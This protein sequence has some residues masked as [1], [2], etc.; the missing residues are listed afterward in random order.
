[1][2]DSENVHYIAGGRRGKEVAD[3]AIT[4]AIAIFEDGNQEARYEV[5]TVL[6]TERDDWLRERNR[7][8]GDLGAADAAVKAYDAAIAKLSAE[9]E[10]ES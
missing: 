5:L 2:T 10:T 1:M 8:A 9:E 6:R 7:L 4:E 3:H